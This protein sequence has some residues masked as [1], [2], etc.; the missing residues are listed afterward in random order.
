MCIHFIQDYTEEFR[1][2]SKGKVKE[3]I[4]AG[5]ITL[6]NQ[7]PVGED[8]PHVC[9]IFACF[10]SP[11]CFIISFIFLNFS[12]FIFPP[13]LLSHSGIFLS[14]EQYQVSK[15]LKNVTKEKKKTLFLSSWARSRSEVNPLLAPSVLIA[16][17][18]FVTRYFIFPV[19]HYSC[20]LIFTGSFAM[21]KVLFFRHNFL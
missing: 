9:F 20:Q 8:L 2:I 14:K 16:A 15:I 13:L 11:R 5:S 4:P 10:F 3:S 6:I 19:C 18:Y 12:H 17:F 21:Y 7:R 1:D